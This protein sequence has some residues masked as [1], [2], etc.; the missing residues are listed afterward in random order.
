MVRSRLFHHMVGCRPVAVAIE[1]RPDDPAIQHSG[2]R[3]VFRLRFPSGDDFAVLGKTA[4]PQTVRIRRTTTPACILGSVFFL[5]R[6]F[7]HGGS[8]SPLLDAKN[9]A[10]Q[11]QIL[12][13]PAERSIHLTQNLPGLGIF[14]ASGQCKASAGESIDCCRAARSRARTNPR[15]V[16]RRTAA[17]STPV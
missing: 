14:E 8:S 2:E 10:A 5:K 7:F 16:M 1:Q 4:D 3:F 17:Y 9:Q 11:P 13:S 12:T 6:F 15:R